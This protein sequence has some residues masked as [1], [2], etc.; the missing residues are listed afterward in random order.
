MDKKKNTAIIKTIYA[1]K[2]N[3]KTFAWDVTKLEVVKE[4]ANY[5]SL[6]DGRRI[7]TSSVIGVYPERGRP[8]GLEYSLLRGEVQYSLKPFEDSVRDEVRRRAFEEAKEELTKLKDD[9][10]KSKEHVAKLY[11]YID[12][13]EKLVKGL[14]AI[15]GA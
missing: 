7:E 10:V 6:K 3:A 14:T 4:C 5:I 1:T 2:F 13:Q 11:T 15:M 8:F 12:E 9:L